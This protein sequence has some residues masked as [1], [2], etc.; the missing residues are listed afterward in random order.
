MAWCSLHPSVIRPRDSDSRVP[1]A[2]SRKEADVKLTTSL[3]VYDTPRVR[4]LP[5]R[6]RPV[7]RLRRYGPTALSATELL[8]TIIQGAHALYQAQQ[9][10]VRFG[11]LIGIARASLAELESVDGVG[12]S[13]AV[14]IKAALELGR[15]LM[16]ETPDP[17]PQVRSPA[18]A[19]GLLMAEMG[20]LDK[21][22]LRTL[23]L[24]TKNCVLGSP[25]IYV[26]SVNTTLIHAAEIFQAAIRA[27]C[28]GIIVAHNHPAG[29]PTPSPEDVA[30]TE[31]IVA[32]GKLLDIEV[33]DHLV[34]GHQRYVSLKERRLGFS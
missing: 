9:I 31:Q 11:G 4:H 20:L 3:K 12:P 26:G 22:N 2:F 14:Q 21:E 32:A 7:N 28:A 13:K 30:V 8:A 33:L 29:D 5:A 24:D 17:R 27:N 10:V 6:E 34:I 15:R 1:S 23:L 19:A 18:D 25:T 16:I